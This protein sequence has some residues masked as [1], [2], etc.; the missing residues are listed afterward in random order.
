MLMPMLTLGVPGSGTTAVLLA[1]LMTRNITPGPTLFANIPEVASGM[2]ASLL[3]ANVEPLIRNVPMV[4]GF[5][6]ILQ[7]PANLLLPG[8]MMVS[9]VDIHSLTGSYLHLLP[10]TVFGIMGW[11]FRKLDIPTVPV[12]SG[13][14][15]GNA[16]ENKPAAGDDIV[17]RRLVLS[18]LL[19]HLDR[20]LGRRQPQPPRA[21][22]PAPHHQEAGHADGGDGRA[23]PRRCDQIDERRT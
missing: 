4:K 11:L 13:T 5:V 17:G 1:V 16:M 3:I 9:F 19:G 2:T 6:K 10:M 15:P 12:I 20:S 8:V 14:L 7:S 23:R 21:A 18:L 22:V